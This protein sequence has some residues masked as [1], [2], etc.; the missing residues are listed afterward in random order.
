MPLAASVREV[1]KPTQVKHLAPPVPETAGVQK[2][3]TLSPSLPGLL[4]QCERRWLRPS[5]VSAVSPAFTPLMALSPPFTIVGDGTSLLA[6]KHT[7]PSNLAA[8]PSVILFEGC[9][10]FHVAGTGQA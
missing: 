4:E 6:S 8:R 9:S 5:F 1:R 10:H 7:R 3:R 2:L